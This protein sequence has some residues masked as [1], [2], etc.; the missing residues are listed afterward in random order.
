MSYKLCVVS[1]HLRLFVSVFSLW[2]SSQ[3]I[4]AFDQDW[5]LFIQLNSIFFSKKPKMR[6]NKQS[7]KRVIFYE[8]FLHDCFWEH[9]KS[10]QFFFL[11]IS[12]IL[13]SEWLN[14]LFQVTEFFLEHTALDLAAINGFLIYPSCSIMSPSLFLIL[15]LDCFVWRQNVSF[16]VWFF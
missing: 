7:V 4:S 8:T 15:F 1:L 14:Y 2:F 12:V 16:S 10:F 3:I 6:C 5:P 13:N 9:L 11:F